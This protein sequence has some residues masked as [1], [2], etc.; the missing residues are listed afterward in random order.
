MAEDFYKNISNTF[1]NSSGNIVNISA[2]TEQLQ[3]SP[4]QQQI[5]AKVGDILNISLPETGGTGYQWRIRLAQGLYLLNED[6]Q[7]SCPPNMVG[8]PLNLVFT[9]EINEPGTLLFIAI[10]KRPWEDI[11][12]YQYQ[13]LINS[14]Y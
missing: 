6:F 5:N 14:S 11:T 1:T 2:T 10:Y 4:F 9:Y 8:C 13:L 7:K 12:L 3:K